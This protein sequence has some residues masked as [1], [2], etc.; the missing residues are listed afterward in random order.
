MLGT[1]EPWSLLPLRIALGG[2][3][4]VHG[5]QKLL[6]FGFGGVARYLA[7]LGGFHPVMFWAVVLTL[8]E[9]LGGMAILVGFMTRWAALLIA[10]EMVI[11]IDRVV[12]RTGFFVPP[13]GMEFNLALI[14]A[15][16]TLL[17]AGAKKPSVDRGLSKES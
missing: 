4:I 16:L 17:A 11:A 12:W 6:V 13:I 9:L 10:V 2:I 7:H 8:V 15:C 3:F 1:A 14:G 5:S